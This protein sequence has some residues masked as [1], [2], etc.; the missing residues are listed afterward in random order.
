M[1]HTLGC[2]RMTPTEEATPPS[3]PIAGLAPPVRCKNCDAILGGRYCAN[4]G[5]SAD[6]HVLSTRELLHEVLEGL[7]HSDS[8][9]WRTL[10]LLLFRPGALTVEFLA[11]RRARSLPPF[12]LY[13]IISIAF[14]LAVS[15]TQNPELQFAEL[16]ISDNPAP[17]NAPLSRLN[18]DDVNLFN[19][20]NPQWT[21]RIRHACVEIRR[22][23]ARTLRKNFVAALPKAM[24]IL[25]PLVA[26]LHML[27]Y[28]HPRRRYAEQL[29]F[30]LHLQSFFFSVG[31]VMVLLGD[32]AH[33]WAQLEGIS[34][35]VRFLLGWTLPIYTVIALR[36]VFRNRWLKTILKSFA[37][38]FAY[39]VLGFGIW[40]AALAY[41]ALEL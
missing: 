34:D 3:A 1:A 12:R 19:I 2:L 5:Q 6:V 18:C 40:M 8:R 25:L 16:S 23:N 28:W 35:V 27:L 7:T 26:F 9:L 31:I 24:F 17:A 22:D 38:A 4:C 29:V 10:F 33:R 37:L 13:L 32:L 11:G 30:F 39:F 41:A 15:V 20:T 21:R 14:F 36:R